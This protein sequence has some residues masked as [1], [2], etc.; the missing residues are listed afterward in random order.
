MAPPLLIRLAAEADAPAL[1]ALYRQCRSEA[2]WLPPLARQRAA[3][4]D[5]AA[6][7]AGELVLVAVAGDG[8]VAG[9]L[10]VWTA[11]GFIH[12]L[13]VAPQWRRRGVAPQLLA[14]LAQRVAPPWRLKCLCANRTALAFYARGGS[15]Q[16]GA[17]IGGDGAYLELE[18]P[19]GWVGS[20]G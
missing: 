7:S 20:A 2:D 16:L 17:G 3:E 12:H 9:L 1:Q 10:A 19:G 18:L 13:Y 15:R 5:F 14:A 6:D 11:D 8:A 4:A